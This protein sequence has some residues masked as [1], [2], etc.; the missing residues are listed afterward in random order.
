[1]YKS[2]K[3]F[4]EEELKSVKEA[5]LFKKE[6]VITSPQGAQVHVENTDEVVIMCANNYL[7]LS[8]HPDVIKASKD[9]LDTHGFGMSSVRFIC[10]TQDI[11][12]QCVNFGTQE[13][14]Y[15]DYVK[16]ANIAGFVK[17]ADAMID[18]GI[19]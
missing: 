3:F 15:I 4:L 17:V 19:V 6:R 7:G 11:H 2:L 10:G 12:K 18:Q 16:G 8:S 13:D 9:A 14:G 1:M 5:G